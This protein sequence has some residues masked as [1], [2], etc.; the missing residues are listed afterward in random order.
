[1]TNPGAGTSSQCFATLKAT[2]KG[3]TLVT[4][5]QANQGIYNCGPKNLFTLTD[6]VG[7]ETTLADVGQN[8]KNL[9]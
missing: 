6:N 1:M 5:T 7:A 9:K 2:P 4:D 8:I 3:F